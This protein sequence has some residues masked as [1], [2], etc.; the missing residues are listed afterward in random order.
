MAID[1]VF[2]SGFTPRAKGVPAA[3]NAIRVNDRV[4]LCGQLY[5]KGTGIHWVH[6]NC[7]DKPTAQ[8]PN[9]WIR[10]VNADGSAGP[11]LEDNTQF[12]SLF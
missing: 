7:G 1:N 4:E 9:G 3:F 10:Q 6:N 12:C 2:A 8:H 5:T 11:N